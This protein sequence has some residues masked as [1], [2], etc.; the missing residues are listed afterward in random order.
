MFIVR[1]LVNDIIIY[2]I[3]KGKIGIWQ[4]I[5]LFILNFE[6]Q[7]QRAAVHKRNEE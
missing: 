3:Y 5:Y 2:Y 6:V 1:T 7:T 4:Y